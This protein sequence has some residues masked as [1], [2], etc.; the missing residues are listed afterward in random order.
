MIFSRNWILSH[1]SHIEVVC[2][3]RAISWDLKSSF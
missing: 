3:R 1:E 2:T